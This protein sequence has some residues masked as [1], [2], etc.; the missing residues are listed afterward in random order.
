MPHHRMTNEQ[1]T[2]AR[3]LAAAGGMTHKAIGQAV[4]GFSASAVRYWVSVKL[5]RLP[6]GDVKLADSP[7]GGIRRQY[8]QRS[9]TPQGCEHYALCR[10]ALREHWIEHGIWTDPP[11]FATLERERV[12]E[13]PR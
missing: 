6:F 1:V 5:H 4:G 2:R 9:C 11:C 3:K 8:H 12:P 7:H 13:P 10:R